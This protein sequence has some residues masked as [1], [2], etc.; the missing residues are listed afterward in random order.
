[1]VVEFTVGN[2]LSF[3]EQRTVSFKAEGISE[4]KEN[5]I[6]VDKGKYKLLPS[7]VVYGANSS[8]KSNLI[9]AMNAMKSFVLNS[10]KLNKSDSLVYVPF[11]L[12]NEKD[13]PTYF[14]MVFLSNAGERFRY[15]FSYTEKAI[16]DEWLYIGNVRKEKTLFLRTEEGIG[17][18]DSFEEGKGKEEVTNDNRLFLSLVAQLGGNISN[19]VMDCFGCYNVISGVEDDKYAN[20]SKKIIFEKSEGWEDV[21]SF[22]QAL[23]LGFTDIEVVE[24][25]YESSE[26]PMN[27]APELREE[28]RK[29]KEKGKWFSTET[30]HNRYDKNGNIIDRI[31]WPYESFESEGTKKIIS[32]SGPIFDTLRVGTLLVIDELDAKLHPLLTMEIIRLFNNR[33]TNPNNAQ[34]LFATHDTNLL[35]SNLFRR[36]QIWFT[37]KDKMEQT[38]LYALHNVVLPDRTKVRNDANL[39][40]NYLRGRFGAIPFITY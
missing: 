17:V 36:D 13:A 38:D 15:G 19:Q 40:K 10:V 6:S 30:V 39:E 23:K 2:F 7:I 28:F 5:L 20:F 9:R 14:E 25:S 32:I 11:L 22:F 12:S 26:S 29:Q 37:E 31:S 8:G 35:S 27:V 21:Q 34:L 4:L 1:M 3:H 16:V 33:G 24:R 18:D